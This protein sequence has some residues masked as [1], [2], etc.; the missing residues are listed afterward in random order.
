MRNPKAAAPP[1]LVEPRL[2]YV[3]DSPFLLKQRQNLH[4]ILLA[5]HQAAFEIRLDRHV[6][7][8]PPT[9]VQLLPHSLCHLG[10]R[11]FQAFT[12]IDGVYYYLGIVDRLVVFHEIFD[13]LLDR[14]NFSRSKF[15]SIPKLN[16]LLWLIFRL[17][18]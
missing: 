8:E 14:L 9:Y 12:L 11:Y 1:S 18:N 7:G 6:P 13:H 5:E 15:S 16:Q 10:P 4:R 17:V 3:D 2:I